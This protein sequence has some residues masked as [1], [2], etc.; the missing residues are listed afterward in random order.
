MKNNR[1]EDEAREFKASA[2]GFSTAPQGYDMQQVD[3]YVDELRAENDRLSD[4]NQQLFLLWVSELRHLAQTGAE[5]PDVSPDESELSWKRINWLMNQSYD[6][7]KLEPLS[8]QVPRPTMPIPVPVP[9]QQVAIA[10]PQEKRSRVKS[11]I[12]GALFYTF[13][14]TA[15]LMVYMF[16]MGNPTGPPRDIAG[17]SV[18]TVLTRSMQEDIPQHSLIMTRRVDPATIQVGDDITYLMPN[19]TTVTHRVIEIYPNYRNTGMPGFRTQGTAN[20]RPDAEV[21]SGANLVGLV[22]FHSLSLGVGILFIRQNVLLIGLT[23]AL[24]IA[25]FVILRKFVFPKRGKNGN[26]VEM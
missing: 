11:A 22:V 12:F 26:N 23:V 15:V 25:S 24:A 6:A 17:F 18:M 3:N 1:R 19:N 7:K 9:V 13:L 16:G 20:P 10:E 8:N 21:V 14:A 5:I 4:V 2:P